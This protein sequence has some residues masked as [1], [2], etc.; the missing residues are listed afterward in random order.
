MYNNGYNSINIRALKYYT[1]KNNKNTYSRETG[2]IFIVKKLVYFFVTIIII[3]SMLM[4]AYGAN[5]AAS[6]F[7]DVKSGQWFYNDVMALTGKGII[8][9]V[10]TPVNGVGKYDPQGTVTLGQ[11]LAISTRLVAEDHIKAVP[12]AK[13]WAEANYIAAVDSELI[14][15]TDFKNS[16]EALNSPISREDMAYILVN[17]ARANG[18]ELEETFGITHNI[19]DYYKVGSKRCDAV[20]RA[21]SNGLIVGDN[22]GNFNPQ[23]SLTRAEVA[24]VF[25]RLM[26]YTKRPEVTVKWPGTEDPGTGTTPGREPMVLRYD[27]PDRP[28]PIAGDTFID[29]NGNKTVLTEAG[30]VV[31]YGQGLDLYS[32]MKYPNGELLT[33]GD[34]GSEYHGDSR[35]MGQ[36]YMVDE[37]TGE[38]HFR[39]D[40]LDV[41]K[42]EMELAVKNKNPKDGQKVGYWTVYREKFSMWIWVGP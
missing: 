8:T 18:E 22:T 10:T 5:N 39:G 35:Y 23:Q 36:P 7:S 30:G 9:G 20:I 12:N 13:H 2:R 15:S 27:D 37:K 33:D 14:Q 34:I 28:L 4:P 3:A 17:M 38:G 25:C 32:G 26:K 41:A 29:K 11:F 1:I 16:P 21:Y 40:W 19:N 6:S 42:Y 24:T 31:G